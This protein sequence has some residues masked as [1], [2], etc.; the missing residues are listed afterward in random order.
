[1]VGDGAEQAGGTRERMTQWVDRLSAA[2]AIPVMAIGV[3]ATGP[4]AGQVHVVLAED[5]RLSRAY[6]QDI[7]QRVLR[8]VRSGRGEWP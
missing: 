2:G 1:M 8:D 3:G 7:L 4:H 6:V 5:H